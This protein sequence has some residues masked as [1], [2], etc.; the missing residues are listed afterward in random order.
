MVD[1]VWMK[2][3][4]NAYFSQASESID[5]ANYGI[6]LSKSDAITKEVRYINEF[7]L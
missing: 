2:M 1:S 5:K 7:N 3:F 4:K 6:K